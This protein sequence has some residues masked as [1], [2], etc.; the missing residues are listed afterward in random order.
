MTG[1]EL[2]EYVRRDLL[3]DSAYPY[4]WGD[5]LIMMYLNEAEKIMAEETYCL[6][7]DT[8]AEATVLNIGPGESEYDLHESVLHVYSAT[9]DGDYFPL[10]NVTHRRVPVNNLAV[11]GRPVCYNLDESQNTITFHP[12]PDEELTI[13]LRVAR[14][15]LEDFTTSTEP[16][17]NKRLHM[18]MCEYAAYKCMSAPDADGFN[19]KAAKEFQAS[20]LRRLVKA[21][22]KYYRLRH[23]TVGR[24]A[25]NWTGKR[26]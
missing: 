7:D 14:L 1:A 15:P 20:W 12:T 21:K 6:S 9:I 11:T 19:P 18:D 16:E 10:H 26:R 2:L 5:A 17:I 24:A 4:L 25:V 8:S 22:R 23:G 13:L 3:R